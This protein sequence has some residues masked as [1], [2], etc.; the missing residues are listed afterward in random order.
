MYPTVRVYG[1][2]V[3]DGPPGSIL[4]RA[5]MWDAVNVVEVLLDKGARIQEEL[6]D[7]PM[8]RVTEDALDFP[9]PS[10]LSYVK[11]IKV[12]ELLLNHGA[13]SSI[14][15]LGPQRLAPLEILLYRLSRLPP[16]S[17]MPEATLLQLIRFF[18]SHGASAQG[19]P[20]AGPIPSLPGYASSPIIAAVY[21]RSLRAFE[22]LFRAAAYAVDATQ[23]EYRL[24]LSMILGGDTLLDIGV[25]EFEDVQDEFCVKMLEIMLR[26]QPPR[27]PR[28]FRALLSSAIEHKRSYVFKTLMRHG[29][30]PNYTA[31]G[32]PTAI[33][34]VIIRLLENG[35]NVH[36]AVRMI[37]ILVGRGADVNFPSFN[38]YGPT[39]LRLACCDGVDA[40]VF[41]TLLDMRAEAGG[42]WKLTPESKETSIVQALIGCG[43]PTPRQA[44]RLFPQSIISTLC[45]NSAIH[46]DA[47]LSHLAQSLNPHHFFRVQDEHIVTWALK[48]LSARQLGTSLEGLLQ[49]WHLTRMKGDGSPAWAWA[50]MERVEGQ[51]K[52]G[53]LSGE[54]RNLQA[55]LF[56]EEKLRCEDG[57]T[58]LHRICRLEPEVGSKEAYNDA[59]AQFGDDC[60]VFSHA[61]LASLGQPIT[62]EVL[63]ATEEAYRQIRREGILE[64]IAIAV[65]STLIDENMVSDE[66]VTALDLVK[67]EEIRRVMRGLGCWT[68]REI[69]SGEGEPWPRF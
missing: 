44:S 2:E 53:S 65:E 13:A 31:A 28:A 29:A 42:G 40:R 23:V 56:C 68:A 46:R 49:T 12:A 11:S 22:A 66:G 20:N 61:Y 51:M 52:F 47:K 16:Q 41:R 64:L 59:T 7:H 54:A 27:T 48:N 60:F 35:S 21:L 38:A 67:D 14:N 1:A 69:E 15:M 57:E 63:K 24:V 33:L 62:W 9:H 25:D 6:I 30:D 5:V 26:V 18:L 17:R 4:A 58:I 37:R 50:D 10:P 32:V 34:E 3:L 8:P 45:T 55:V 36:E 39:P 19:I 43:I